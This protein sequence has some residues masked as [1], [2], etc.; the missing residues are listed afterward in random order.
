MSKTHH[1]DSAIEPAQL[2]RNMTEAKLAAILLHEG[3]ALK[4]VR[5]N[6]ARDN[7]YASHNSLQ[8]KQKQMDDLLDEISTYTKDEAKVNEITLE[9][10]LDFYGKLEVEYDAYLLRHEADLAVHD[11]IVGE[12]WRP[13]VKRAAQKSDA[14]KR[15]KALLK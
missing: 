1:R 10:K 5:M 15:A 9:K 2:R 12:K 4:Y 13:P 7:C 3:D 11:Q 14:L 8:F 6:E